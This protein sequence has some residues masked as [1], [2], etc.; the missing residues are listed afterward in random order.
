M[1]Q[2][3]ASEVETGDSN[4]DSEKNNAKKKASSPFF[5]N[6]HSFNNKINAKKQNT[7]AASVDTKVARRPSIFD[8]V[9]LV[10]ESENEQNNENSEQLKSGDRAMSTLNLPTE[11]NTNTNVLPRL[12]QSQ[13]PLLQ[14]TFANKPGLDNS[15]G[16]TI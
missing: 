3:S 8:Y 16:M 2:T 6:I 5:L 4:D 9:D 14:I 11:M 7:L 15:A 10:V 13:I 12:S 1:S